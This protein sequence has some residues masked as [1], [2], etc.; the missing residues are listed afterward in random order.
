[1]INPQIK[2]DPDVLFKITKKEADFV[3]KLPRRL[4]AEFEDYQKLRYKFHCLA[5]SY[6]KLVS[7]GA[8]NSVDFSS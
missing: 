8:N 1:M 3:L 5:K 7:M 6:P 2:C 4:Q